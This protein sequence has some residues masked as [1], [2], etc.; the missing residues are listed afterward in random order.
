MPKMFSHVSAI[1]H[2][3]PLLVLFLPVILIC[4]EPFAGEPSDD[5]HWA[6][7]LFGLGRVAD[8]LSVSAANDHVFVVVSACASW[9]SHNHDGAQPEKNQP[10]TKMNTRTRVKF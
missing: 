2:S 3:L 8:Q 9:T 4:K 6:V 10:I 5:C 1:S 7:V